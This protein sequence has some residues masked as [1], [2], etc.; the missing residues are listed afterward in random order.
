LIASHAP[1]ERRRTGHGR[2][3]DDG[4]QPVP[5]THQADGEANRNMQPEHREQ[6]PAGRFAQRLQIM[7]LM[8]HFNIHPFRVRQAATA[9]GSM[10]IQAPASRSRL[11]PARSSGRTTRTAGMAVVLTNVALAEAAAWSACCALH[12]GGNTTATTSVSGRT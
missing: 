5:A 3:E 1:R 11:S 6:G 12:Q 10:A 8:Y 9:C 7:A 2:R 4:K